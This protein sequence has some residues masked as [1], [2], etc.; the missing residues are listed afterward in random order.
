MIF[1]NPARV[2]SCFSEMCL[3]FSRNSTDDDPNDN[4]ESSNGG[5][6]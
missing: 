6:T 4:N 1:K 2:S 3:G 5:D